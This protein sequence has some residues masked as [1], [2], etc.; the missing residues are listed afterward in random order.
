MHDANGLAILVRIERAESVSDL[1][2]MFGGS[3][4]PA[5]RRYETIFEEDGQIMLEALAPVREAGARGSIGEL[6]LVE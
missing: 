6:A 4:A 1:R 2:P 3:V 5:A